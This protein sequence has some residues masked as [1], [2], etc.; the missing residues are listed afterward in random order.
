MAEFAL[1]TPILIMLLVIVADFGRI[2]AAGIAMEAAARNAAEIGANEYLANPPAPLN[3]PAPAGNSVY[4]APLHR[5][6]AKAVCVETAELANSMF[7]AASQTCS[8]MPLIQACVHDGQDTECNLEA[9]GAVIP[10]ACNDMATAPT[11]D[12][13]PGT[14]AARWVEVRVCYRFTAILQSPI[15]S[16][17]E[18]W[19]QRT[20]TFV[21]PCYFVL[22]TSECA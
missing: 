19:L 20:R 14:P 13:P 16:F 8:G 17:G 4:Y 5:L 21:I 6:M 10:A 1:I 9:H 2:F 12:H 7:D 11:N 3:L 18:F 22:G 15:L